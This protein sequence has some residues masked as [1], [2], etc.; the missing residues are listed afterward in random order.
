MILS[1]DTITGGS[2]RRLGQR[3]AHVGPGCPTGVQQAHARE[4]Y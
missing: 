3:K 4:S 1:S 2:G